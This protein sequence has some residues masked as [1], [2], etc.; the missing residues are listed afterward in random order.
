MQA[1]GNNEEFQPHGQAES[2]SLRER[3]SEFTCIVKL[4]A[5]LSAVFSDKSLNHTQIKGKQSGGKAPWGMAGTKGNR[6]KRLTRQRE[7]WHFKSKG[8]SK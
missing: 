3:E 6:E 4:L 7:R 5:H 8:K 1:K 2:E